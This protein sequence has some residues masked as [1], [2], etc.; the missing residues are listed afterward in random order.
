MTSGKEGKRPTNTQKWLGA[1]EVG[2]TLDMS[3][4]STIPAQVKTEETTL[5]DISKAPSLQE[6]NKVL[7]GH[8]LQEVEEEETSEKSLALN[9][10]G[11]S[12]YFAGKIKDIQ[13]GCVKSW[14]RSKKK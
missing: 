7:T 9:P 1:S 14:S 2:S 13:Q 10:E 11:C 12:V 3:E 5:K 8:Q 6:R 4:Q